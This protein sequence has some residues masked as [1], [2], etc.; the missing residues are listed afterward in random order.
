ME[1]KLIKCPEGCENGWIAIYD[2][3]TEQECFY[4]CGTCNGDGYVSDPD[5]FNNLL[6]DLVTAKEVSYDN[7]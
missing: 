6:S 3:K 4:L 2:H 5:N 7:D 1:P